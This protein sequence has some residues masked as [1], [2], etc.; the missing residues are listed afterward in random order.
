MLRLYHVQLLGI[1][2]DVAEGM[3]YLHPAVVHRDLKSSNVLLDTD[4]R[5][6]ISDFGIAAFKE[7]WAFWSPTSGF[8]KLLCTLTSSYALGLLLCTLLYELV[9][10]HTTSQGISI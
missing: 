8:K 6:K 5:A 7:R 3:A 4:G 9:D 1:A 2:L 10:L